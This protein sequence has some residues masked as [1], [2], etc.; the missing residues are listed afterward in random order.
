MEESAPQENLP[1]NENVVP[2]NATTIVYPITPNRLTTY[3]HYQQFWPVLLL[4]TI[5]LISILSICDAWMWFWVIF[6][7]CVFF[8]LYRIS[9]N[10]AAKR[11][12]SVK[13]T[14]VGNTISAERVYCGFY[15]KKVIELEQVTRISLLQTPLMKFCDIWAIEFMTN[16]NNCTRIYGI[17]NAADVHRHLVEAR[18]ISLAAVHHK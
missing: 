11:T 15:S 3:V 12:G 2:E 18:A 9:T 5:A 6:T 4:T 1:T 7:L 10:I 8:V 17:K 13:Y 16:A 14:R